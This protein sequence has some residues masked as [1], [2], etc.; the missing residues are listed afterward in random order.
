MTIKI[1]GINGSPR[2]YGNTYKMLK[3]AL[4]SAKY[5][6]AKIEIIDLYEKRIEPCLGCLTDNQYACRY[7]CVIKDDM[8]EIYKIILESDGLIFA[9]PVY[10][11]NMSGPMKNLVDRITVFENMVYFDEYSWVEG[12]TAGIIAAGA[13][14]GTAMVVSNLMITL[15]SYGMM[16]PPWGFAYFTGKEDVLTD[17]NAVLDAINVGRVVYMAIKGEKTSR[18]YDPRPSF[19]EEVLSRVK[20]ECEKNYKE[21]FPGRKE[22]I[23]TLL[24]SE[25]E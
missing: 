15:N 25:K 7:P 13:E 17:T 16:I 21:L 20:E 5:L 14:S 4:Y 23:F 10:W 24:D 2:K 8:Q 3:L 19:L 6:G 22:K 9:T 12:K 11:F 18:W 1:L